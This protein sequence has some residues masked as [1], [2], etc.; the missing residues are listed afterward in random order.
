MTRRTRG[1]R[2]ISGPFRFFPHKLVFMKKI[3]S[4]ALF[5]LV[6]LFFI[7]PSIVSAQTAGEKSLLEQQ[8]EAFAGQQGANFGTPRDPPAIAAT[9]INMLLGLLGL[10]M[11][12]YFVYGGYLIMTSAGNEEKVSKGKHV[13]RN[14]VIGLVL[15]LSA[16][17]IARL[18]VRIASGGQ[19][20]ED[21]FT[22]CIERPAN[23]Q[24]DIFGEDINKPALPYCDEI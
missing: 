20:S 14:A 18:V 2:R 17:A 21:G 9:L 11:I 19:S 15:I 24:Q 6:C 16:Y 7:S 10:L 8:T 3:R 13:I 22:A 5:A 1:R 12:V 23:M 4:I